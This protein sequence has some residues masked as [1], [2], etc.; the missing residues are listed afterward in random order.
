MFQ[1]FS[2]PIPYGCA[3]HGVARRSA[4]PGSH[5]FFASRTFPSQEAAIEHL[6]V[7]MRQ[8]AA[9]EGGGPQPPPTP[10]AAVATAVGVAGSSGSF[11]ASVRVAAAATPDQATWR[12]Q[13]H[14]TRESAERGER[15]SGRSELP[16]ARITGRDPPP[17]GARVVEVGPLPD[18][19][20]LSPARFQPCSVC[21]RDALVVGSADPVCCSDCRTSHGVCH[22]DMC[23][24]MHAISGAGDYRTQALRARWSS[25]AGAVESASM[26]QPASGLSPLGGWESRGRRFGA[27]DDDEGD[28]AGVAVGVA[29]ESSQRA[30][31]ALNVATEGRS[32]LAA[33]DERVARVERDGSTPA[34]AP[35]AST[36]DAAIKRHKMVEI[37]AKQRDARGS[38]LGHKFSH[39]Q[40]QTLVILRLCGRHAGDDPCRVGHDLTGYELFEHL[41]GETV[42][43]PT[44]REGWADCGGFATLGVMARLVDLYISCDSKPGVSA[45]DTPRASVREMAA[46]EGPGGDLTGPGLKL[47]TATLKAQK[48]VAD[49]TMRIED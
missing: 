25:G 16:P 19:R 26:L 44:D 47:S 41:V 8:R 37:A 10:P 24:G 22:G 29:N 34:S 42:V 45:R 23:D 36:D 43:P 27:A 18:G 15:A 2:H 9:G 21:A 28:R 12:F 30:A 11:D 4:D 1:V 38:A 5:G 32:A 17:L 35:A 3:T 31:V 20:G 14:T 13:A 40:A 46:T 6:R 49:K 39:T 48:L 7:E 33:L